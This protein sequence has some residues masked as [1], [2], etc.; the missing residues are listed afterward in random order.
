[1]TMTQC[2]RSLSSTT[3]IK[4]PADSSSNV[5]DRV[6]DR[7][8]LSR[9]NF[10]LVG[11]SRPAAGTKERRR[12][13]PTRRRHETPPPAGSPYVS[14]SLHLCL[15]LCLSFFFFL[16]CHTI[17]DILVKIQREIMCSAH[18]VLTRFCSPTI[19]RLF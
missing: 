19:G 14:H 12:A 5:D 3:L 4:R 16:G 11:L 2:C 6:L 7:A 15:S 8:L 17:H 10:V 9:G 18:V 13:T 1:M